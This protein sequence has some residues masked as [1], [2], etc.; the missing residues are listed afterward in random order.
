MNANP[1]PS[2]H[3]RY[4][5]YIF[6]QFAF[7]FSKSIATIADIL[8]RAGVTLADIERALSLYMRLSEDCAGRSLSVSFTLL[9]L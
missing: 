7:S 6:V 3:F 5:Q 4:I 1:T 2:E 8:L 9:F